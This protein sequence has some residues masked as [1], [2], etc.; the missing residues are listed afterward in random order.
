MGEICPL[1]NLPCDHVDSCDDLMALLLG[2]DNPM[3][4]RKYVV[5]AGGRKK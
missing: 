2:L 3:D 1:T 5:V 4:C